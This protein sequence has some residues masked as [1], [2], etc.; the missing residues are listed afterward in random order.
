MVSL[1][2]ISFA[3]VTILSGYLA[4]L[5][6]VPPNP[7]PSSEWGKDSI[8]LVSH[9]AAIFASRLV[10][11]GSCL[12]HAMV[13]VL[14]D[15]RTS[16]QH[17]QLNPDLFRWTWASSLGLLLIFIGASLRLAAF[18]ALG[19][20][21]TFSLAKPNELNTRGIY[22]YIQHPSYSGLIL[23]VM[24]LHLLIFRWDGWPAYWIPQ[25]ILESLRGWGCVCCAVTIALGSIGLALRVSEEEAMLKEVFGSKWVTW[26]KKTKRFVPGVI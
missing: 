20:R 14:L 23:V 3:I 11:F 18:G 17:G 16:P 5:C 1:S 8:H 7:N 26:S 21:F 13:A 10:A 24:P 4:S 25:S 15:S 9:P 12:H 19:S 6:F 22:A 2:T